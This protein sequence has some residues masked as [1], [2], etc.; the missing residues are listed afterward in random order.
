M[1]RFKMGESFFI[2]MRD[3]PKLSIGGGVPNFYSTSS[4]VS[5]PSSSP[6]SSIWLMALISPRSVLSFLS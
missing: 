2:Y 1:L 3:A 4:F 6:M 5:S